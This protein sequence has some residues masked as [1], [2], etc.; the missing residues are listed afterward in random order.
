MRWISIVRFIFCIFFSIWCNGEEKEAAPR[1]VRP[2]AGET[3]ERT[4]SHAAPFFFLFHSSRLEPSHFSAPLM[5]ESWRPA[6]RSSFV[7]L[8]YEFYYHTRQ[9]WKIKHLWVFCLRAKSLSSTRL[10]RLHAVLCY[11]RGRIPA[12]LAAN[13]NIRIKIRRRRERERKKNIC[14]E[15]FTSKTQKSFD[16]F[17]GIFF[18][19]HTKTRLS[20]CCCVFFLFF[21]H[22]ALLF[23]SMAPV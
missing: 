16:L 4:F 11:K 13:E 19:T 17:S 22:T 8:R 18:K 3:A 21:F 14:L 23:G 5:S 15:R 7:F 10:W 20:R 6:R 1:S 9:T 2:L 12:L